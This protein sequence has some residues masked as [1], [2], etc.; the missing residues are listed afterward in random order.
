MSIF[1]KILDKLGF[2]KDDKSS[3]AS[4]SPAAKSP[5]FNRTPSE[6]AASRANMAPKGSSTNEVDVVG[7]LEAL[8]AA[9]PE[10]LDWKMS[11]VDLLKL[12][13][14]DSSREARNEMADEL[15]IPA[16]MKEDSA[17]MNIWLHK[18]VLKKIADNGGNVPK[19]LLD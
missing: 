6:S 1:S 2:G 17:R 8:A 12:L 14:I 18:T 13:D 5:S 11:I 7:K 3:G 16:D 9:N 15:G 4:T 19:S 10:K